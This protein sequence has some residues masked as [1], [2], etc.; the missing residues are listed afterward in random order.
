MNKRKVLLFTRLMVV[1]AG[2]SL[3]FSIS[4]AQVS[5]DSNSK[6]KVRASSRSTAREKDTSTTRLAKSKGVSTN[7][8]FAHYVSS[9][10]S[11][12]KAPAYTKSSA[13]TKGKPD[14]MLMPSGPTD[15]SKVPHY[16]GPYPN[17]ANSPFRL[18]DV[19]VA[20]TGGGGTGATAAA[21]VD[22]QTG[23]VAHDRR[24]QPRQRLHVRADGRLHRRHRNRRRGHRDRRLQRRRQRDHRRRR[25]RR[26]HGADGRHLPVAAPRR[27]R[28]ATAFGG[29]DA[30]ALV[31]GTDYSG[32]TMP[33]IEFGLPNDPAGVQATGHATCVEDP[34]LRARRRRSRHGQR[35]R[36]RHRGLR[37]LGGAQRD[38][39]RRSRRL[40]GHAPS[41]PAR[42]RRSSS[43]RSSLDTFGAGYTSAPTV[44]ISDATGTGTGA[45]ATASITT[46]G[47]S[48]TA[49]TVDAGG[50]G[51]MTPGIKKFT[52]DLPGPLHAP[53]LPGV[54][55]VHPARRAREQDLQRR[56]VRRVRHRPRAVPHVVL[57]EPAADTLVRGYVQLETHGERRHQPA[58][59][60]VNELLDGTTAPVLINGVQAL[61]VT[62]PQWLGPTIV[63]TKD[64][65]VRIVFHNL[66]PTGADG[67]LFL[68]TDSHA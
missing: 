39:P 15:E 48:V 14:R 29:V 18:P 50:A 33:I 27:T 7:S 37:L 58:L 53:G 4:S 31:A 16:F 63:A 66:L 47:G 62:P 52:D 30:A 3:G 8:R 10:V 2:L 64:K 44:T 56:R 51:Y 23:A 49:I 60:A 67:D 20:L 46:S 11:S 32:Y 65:P 59:P 1:I 35:H 26:L 24:H 45:A 13:S 19:A 25:G 28:P 41:R 21:T 9:V 38:D 34:S 5:R 22:A 6:A 42:R 54:R 57:V 36:R 55:Q 43:R 68:P 61:G 40:A 17:W 12:R